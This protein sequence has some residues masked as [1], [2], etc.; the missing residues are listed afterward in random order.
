LC[1]VA[2]NAYGAL[3]GR[4]DVEHIGGAE[5]QQV[6]VAFD[7]SFVVK[8][9][10][11][12]DAEDCG[13]IR[14]FKAFAP[15]R[16]LPGIRFF[17]PRLTALWSAM[18]RADADVYYQRMAETTTAIVAAFCR[19]YNRKF[20]FATAAHYDCLPREARF[21]SAREDWL[22]RY[23]LRRA[24]RVFVQT[25]QQRELLRQN[26]G[27]DSV[28]VRN[29]GIAIRDEEAGAPATRS[30]PSASPRV[31]WI[32]RV[33]REKDPLLALDVAA[34]CPFAAFDVMGDG[35][36]AALNAT[37][38]ERA[39]AAPN[40][41][42]HG[43]VGRAA[44]ARAYGQADLLLLTSEREGFP[45][46][47]LEAFSCGIPVVSTVDPD[48]L[49]VKHGPGR[50]ASTPE[51]LAEAVRELTQSA[52]A[53][54]DCSRRA[55]DYYRLFHDPAVVLALYEQQVRELLERHAV[56]AADTR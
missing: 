49:V 38:R 7:V 39:A 17:H 44:I 11:Q 30:G 4:K 31:L 19:R 45:N 15:E 18:R 50:V 27:H 36:D 5:M 34:R 14:A 41:V 37:I 1:F 2:P 46:V 35:D 16:G 40:V 13:G 53:W 12:E 10:G 20:I 23:G 24:D 26:F 43:Y 42:L 54:R 25:E 55:R 6:T 51:G 21:R 8:D 56:P 28:V 32:G 22:Y 52:V 47:F 3:S 48:G 9:H 29:C 33:N